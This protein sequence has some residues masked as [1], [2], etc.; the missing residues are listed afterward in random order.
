MRFR[1]WGTIGLTAG[2]IG[3]AALAWAALDYAKW[4]SLGPGGLPANLNGWVT[5]TRYRLIAQDE[6]DAGPIAAKVGSANDLRSWTKLRGRSGLRPEVSKYP[7]PHR[8]VSQLADSEAR[9]QL[10]KLFERTVERY[11]DDV[12]LA[13][14]HFEKRHF[15]ITLKSAAGKVGLRSQ[16]EIA[17]IHPRDN[18]MHM[19][20]SPTDALAAVAAGWAQRHSL[21]GIAVGLPV[22]YVM[23]YSPREEQDL[24]VV[25]ELLEAAIAYANQPA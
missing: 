17:H 22:T 5:M 7:I 15:A 2:C 3:A 19:V 13:L 12:H 6:L 18:S 1:G 4:R 11:G 8:Q 21:A 14:S 9:L 16:G 10:S 24:E 23:I 20:L 25:G